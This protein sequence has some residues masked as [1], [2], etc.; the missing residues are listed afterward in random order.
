MLQSRIIAQ[1]D[2]VPLSPVTPPQY[3]KLRR[4]AAGLSILQVAERIAPTARDRSEAIALVTM[5]EQPGTTA[6]R[7][8]TLSAFQS[9]FPFDPDVYQQLVNDPPAWHPAICR[10]C[11]CSQWDPCCS[12]D[13]CCAWAEPG[14]CT[15]CADAGIAAA[16][17]AA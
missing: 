14:R 1:V 15:R 4:Q 11:G 9:A 7:T 8:E 12:D 16:A 13:A 17:H 3:L 6:R 10:S 2:A 5:L